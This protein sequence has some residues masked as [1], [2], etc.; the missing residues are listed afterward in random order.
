MQWEQVLIIIIKR[1][2]LLPSDNC[3]LTTWNSSNENLITKPKLRAFV[4]WTFRKIKSR[5][6][7]DNANLLKC[8]SDN[9]LTD[10]ISPLR[11]LYSMKTRPYYCYIS[12]KTNAPSSKIEFLIRDPTSRHTTQREKKS[13]AI[14]SQQKKV[15]SSF[16]GWMDLARVNDRHDI[17]HNRVGEAILKP[18]T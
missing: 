18:I 11:Q 6:E 14:Q 9:L 2:V 10:D 3:L 7:E 16:S 17:I 8:S 5:C 12:L 4:M 15:F 13:E 1:N